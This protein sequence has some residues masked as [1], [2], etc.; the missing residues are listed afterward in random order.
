MTNT[1]H[2]VC[3]RHRLPKRCSCNVPIENVLKVAGW[4]NAQTFAQY[5]N[6][7]LEDTSSSFAQAVL[8]K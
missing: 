7:K 3:A 8:T 2:I 6:K 1:R 5:Y 4:T